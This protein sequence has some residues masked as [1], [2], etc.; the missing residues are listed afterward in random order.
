MKRAASLGPVAA[1]LAAV[2]LACWPGQ[3]AAGQPRLSA[4]DCGRVVAHVPDASVAYQPGTDVLGR[5][6]APA[7]LA[8]APTVLPPVLGFV[9]SVDLARR[10]ALPRGL[11]A[12]LP[13][14][15]V[16]IEG[17]QLRFNGQPIGSDAEAGLAAACAA[18]RASASA[19]AR[20]PAPG[21]A[22]AP[23]AAMGPRR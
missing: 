14:G 23:A 4:E 2:P 10:L 21:R 13:I 19:S 11:D 6:V 3:P 5:Q 9:L 1:L 7:D 16:T 20:T 22:G 12:D 8:P 18:A 15:I 17:N